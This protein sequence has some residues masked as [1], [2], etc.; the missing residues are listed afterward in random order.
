MIDEA[1]KKGI[2][3]DIKKLKELFFTE[4]VT[5]NARKGIGLEKTKKV[6]KNFNQKTKKHNFF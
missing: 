3:I 6:I 2:F 1:E 4:I 5:I